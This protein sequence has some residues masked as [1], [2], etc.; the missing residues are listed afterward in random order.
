M[1]VKGTE[2]AKSTRCFNSTIR[3]LQSGS[4]AD[5][6]PP[7]SFQ[8]SPGGILSRGQILSGAENREEKSHCRG[9]TRFGNLFFQNGGGSPVSPSLSSATRF[10]HSP[11]FY[12]GLLIA[13][14]F[15]RAFSRGTITSGVRDVPT[16]RDNAYGDVRKA[17]LRARRKASPSGT[18]MRTHAFSPLPPPRHFSR[19]P[20][21]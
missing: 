17:W 11:L 8:F 4:F 19:G 10:V 20:S 6:G 3:S 5:T 1:K 18:S 9:R 12:S 16:R 13:V 15:A 2:C 14:I 7:R 21:T